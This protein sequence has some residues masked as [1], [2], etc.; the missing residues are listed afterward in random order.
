[1]TV[2]ERHAHREVLREAHEGVVD[3][4]VAVRVQAAHDVADDAGA[5]DVAAVGPQAHLAHLEQDAALHRLEPVAC[6]G[7]GARVDDGVRVLEERALH[8]DGDVDVVDALAE[9]RGRWRHG[10]VDSGG[11]IRSRPCYRRRKPTGSALPTCSRIASTRLAGTPRTAGPPAGDARRRAAR[12]RARPRRPE[13]SRGHARTLASRLE[14]D[15]AIGAGFPTTTAVGD[16][17]PDDGRA[18]GTARPGR[19]PRARSRARPGRQSA[20]RLGRAARSATWQRMPTLFETRGGVG[21]GELRDRAQ[22]VPRV[23]IHRRGAARS[24]VPRRRMCSRRRIDRTI[25]VLDRARTRTHLPVRLRPRHD[26]AQPRRR[27]GGV[28]RCARVARCG[29][30]PGWCAPSRRGRGCSSR[31]ITESSTSRPRRRSSWRPSCSSG[32]RHV[33]GEPRCLQLHLE[34]DVDAEDVAE[35]WRENEGPRAWVGTR[36]QAIEAGWF[37]PVDAEVLDRIG[38]VLVAARAR[39]PTTSIR[40]IAAAAWSD[41]TARS[42][43]PR[44]RSRCSGSEPGPV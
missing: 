6:V 11:V 9:A 44:P 12:G 34:S 4:G 24:G 2:D 27:V 29:G 32:V 1:M 31:P 10:E 41:S 21:S 5:L 38:Q 14:L 20:H 22:Q 15:P 33:A 39:S 19:L 43:R 25:E 18:A 8:L 13:A 30:R 35:R 26:R 7:Q 3:R 36:E 37:G 17:D 16:R 42:R 28:D 23:G 40:R